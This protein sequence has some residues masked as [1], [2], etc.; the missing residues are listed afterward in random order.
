MHYQ[1]Q[2][3][4]AGIEFW[5]IVLYRRLYRFLQ[6]KH[7]LF[8]AFSFLQCHTK[9]IFRSTITNLRLFAVNV[10]KFSTIRAFHACAKIAHPFC[11]GPINNFPITFFHSF[12]LS[13]KHVLQHLYRFL[14]C[15]PIAG[16][17]GHA[18]IYSFFACYQDS[19]PVLF[20]THPKGKLY[21]S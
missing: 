12:F 17:K 10:N 9:D 7:V 1:T 8:L 2:G 19:H 6:P 11:I 5:L 18:G 14:F 21:V 16:A 20:R 13:C 4:N 3:R 15:D